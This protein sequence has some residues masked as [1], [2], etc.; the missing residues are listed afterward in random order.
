[1]RGPPARSRIAVNENGWAIYLK[2][3]VLVFIFTK[4]LV[5]CDAFSHSQM[6]R[7]KLHAFASVFART[8][9]LVAEIA[10]KWYPSVSGGSPEANLFILFYFFLGEIPTETKS[11]LDD[12]P[13]NA[14]IDVGDEHRSASFFNLP[15]STE[16]NVDLHKCTIVYVFLSEMV[17]EMCQQRQSHEICAVRSAN[18]GRKSKRF[19]SITGDS[20]MAA[21][22]LRGYVFHVKC[23]HLP[24]ERENRKIRGASFVFPHSCVS[25]T[26]PLNWLPQSK[27]RERESNCSVCRN[28]IVNH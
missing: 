19:C 3:R 1:M 7:L 4:S 6:N 28:S 2:W 24:I 13:T 12:G 14:S 17:D 20:W 8:T 11:N 23:I 21:W 16:T 18:R 27:Q 10:V 9:I 22:Q 15:V 26:R 25:S 5:T